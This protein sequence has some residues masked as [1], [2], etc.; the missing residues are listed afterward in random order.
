MGDE[1][2]AFYEPVRP[3]LGPQLFGISVHSR[4]RQAVEA[5]GSPNLKAEYTIDPVKDDDQGRYG[6]LG[7]L[8]LDVIDYRPDLATACVYDIKTG[9]AHL[10]P[11][12]VLQ[13]ATAVAKH[14]GFVQFIIIEVKPGE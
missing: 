6:K 7:T 13:I 1:A 8:R 4:V 5:V 11:Q 12:R 9:H 14:F 2:A 10:T 3:V